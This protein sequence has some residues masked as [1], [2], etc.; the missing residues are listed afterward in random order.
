[1]LD[2]NQNNQYRHEIAWLEDEI[3]KLAARVV[4]KPR[5]QRQ[6]DNYRRQIK[7]TEYNIS[8]GL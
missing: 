2:E 1:M 8:L 4:K 6:I 5:V 7:E 3:K